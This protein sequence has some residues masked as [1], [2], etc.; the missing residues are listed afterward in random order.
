MRDPDDELY[1]SSNDDEIDR[2]EAYREPINKP[3][4]FGPK[5]KGVHTPRKT[6]L[7][8]FVSKMKDFQQTHQV[9]SILPH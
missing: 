6:T 5:E 3:I 8:P 2:S 9:F 4:T 7:W 1:E